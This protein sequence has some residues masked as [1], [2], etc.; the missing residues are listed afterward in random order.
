MAL[1]VVLGNSLWITPTSTVKLPYGE[2]IF[3]VQVDFG[4]VVIVVVLVGE[5][6]VALS[7]EGEAVL[8]SVQGGWK[9]RVVERHDAAP[10]LLG[11]VGGSRVD[12]GIC[13]KTGIKSFLF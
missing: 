5:V 10:G 2:G 13:R 11:A 9:H 1:K 12:L 7:A 8:V 3:D 4:E 6:I